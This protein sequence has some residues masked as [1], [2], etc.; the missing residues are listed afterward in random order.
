M[1]ASCLWCRV[2]VL[3]EMVVT[4]LYQVPTVAEQV[5]LDATQG[6]FSPWTYVASVWLCLL[7]I[8][9]VGIWLSRYAP[10]LA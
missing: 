3:T 7:P 6:S 5:Y 1:A 4:N 2:P 10:A 8:L 9:A